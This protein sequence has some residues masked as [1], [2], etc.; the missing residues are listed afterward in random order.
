MNNKLEAALSTLIFNNSYIADLIYQIHINF[1]S[2]LPTAGVYINNNKI[3]MDINPFFWGQFDTKGQIAILMHECM[4]LLHNHI[5][6]YKELFGGD[7]SKMRSFN[8]AADVAINQWISNM[9]DTF[10][11]FDKKGENPQEAFG[12][13]FER[14]SKDYPGLLPKETAEYYFN[15]LK[16]NDNEDG[17]GKGSM[18]S[19]DEW[20]E[21]DVSEETIKEIVKDAVNKARESFDKRGIGSLPSDMQTLID[22]LN[23]TP[24]NWKHDIRMFIARSMEVVVEQSRKIRNRRYGI[25][26]P[27]ERKDSKLALALAIDTSGSVGEEEL[28][29]FGAEIDRISEFANVT[30]IE[31]DAVVQRTYTYKKGQKFNINGRGGT[32]YQ[33]AF[34]FANTLDIDGLIY[35]GDMDTSDE[36]KRPKYP[37]LWAIVR[38]SKPPVSWG[39][40]TKI[41]VSKK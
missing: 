38:D 30:V 32:A 21:G 35:F 27:G 24:K 5:P 4:H 1:T 7:T 10:Q 34:D 13:S 14:M 9:P 25:L 20:G 22:I 3:C 19:H 23:Y 6:R 40:S 29:Q 8:I 12:C 17:E 28:A 15:T 41:D 2:R 33:P 36:P 31:A 26:F 37:V 16:N 39:K 18:D 11:V